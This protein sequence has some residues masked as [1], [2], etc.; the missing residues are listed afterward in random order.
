MRRER[1]AEE[2][3][4]EREAAVNN[5]R[6][7]RCEARSDSKSQSRESRGQR[8]RRRRTREAARVA[9]QERRRALDLLDAA[10]APKRGRLAPGVCERGLAAEQ[11]GD[12]GGLRERRSPVS[13]L[14][15][16]ANKDWTCLKEA[17][18][19][20]VEPNLLV[21]V[22]GAEHLGQAAHLRRA[23]LPAGTLAPSRRI[24]KRLWLW[25]VHP[26]AV[27]RT[28]EDDTSA[29]GRRGVR[30]RRRRSGHRL[31]K[32][33]HERDRRSLVVCFS[34]R[35]AAQ[36]V[37]GARLAKGPP[38]PTQGRARGLARVGRVGGDPDLDNARARV[39]SVG[40]ELAELRGG[41]GGERVARGTRAR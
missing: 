34:R 33:A 6:R 7:P 2:S 11:G 14:F 9:R 17:R 13:P 16:M 40:S 19:D 36:D 22:L 29:A 38:D 12:F 30:V 32:L 41:R 26:R 21:C 23:R 15:K 10:D 39:A 3:S 27:R 37:D 31:G 4:N 18:R 24:V 8:S 1:H 20:G 35:A 28:E 5:D 25:Q